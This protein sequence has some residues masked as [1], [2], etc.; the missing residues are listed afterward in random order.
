MS[1]TLTII[2]AVGLNGVIGK[3]GDLAWRDPIDMA[4][5]RKVTMGHTVVMGR[6][7]WE[8]LP[9]KFRP[10]PGR[11][12]IVMTRQEGWK[13]DSV[14]VANGTLEVLELTRDCGKIFVIGGAEVYARFIHFAD[15]LLLTE[16]HTELEGDTYFP[17][18]RRL[19][20]KLSNRVGICPSLGVTPFSFSTWRR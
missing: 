3:G 7:T 11:R 16:V 12:N 4:H 8:S 19:D 17:D 10:L 14:E 1:S 18:W 6:K 15:E 2:A 5:F 20:F 13:A 9:P